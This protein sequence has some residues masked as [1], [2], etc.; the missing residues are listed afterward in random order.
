M[1]GTKAAST[2]ADRPSRYGGGAAAGGGAAGAAAAAVSLLV[3]I[4]ITPA[5]HQLCLL[6]QAAGV[7][8]AGRYAYELGVLE[9]RRYGDLCRELLDFGIPIFDPAVTQANDTLAHDLLCLLGDAA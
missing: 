7:R 3:L 9:L 5:P 1:H 4:A 6:G 8:P 2:F